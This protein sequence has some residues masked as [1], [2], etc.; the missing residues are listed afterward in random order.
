MTHWA[1]TLYENTVAPFP[2]S[3][4]M[5]IILVLGVLLVKPDR[6]PSSRTQVTKPKHN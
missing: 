1:T 2:I 5:L 6:H 3:T 4:F